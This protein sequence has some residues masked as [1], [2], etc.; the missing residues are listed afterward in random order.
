MRQLPELSGQV[1]VQ[2][3][4]LL[5]QA[6]RGVPF[7]MCRKSYSRRLREAVQASQ[8][9]PWICN[10]PHPA[11]QHASKHDPARC[12]GLSMHTSTPHVI[13]S[14]DLSPRLWCR[15]VAAAVS[16]RAHVRA[17]KDAAGDEAV[18][19]LALKTLGEVSLGPLDKL[20]A[21]VNEHVA[22]LMA[23]GDTIGLRRAAALAAARVL[24][25][26]AAAQMPKSP[27][28][29]LLADTATPAHLAVSG[30]LL[31][32]NLPPPPPPP[33]PAS[34]VSACC[35]CPSSA[36]GCVTLLHALLYYG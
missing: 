29:S 25:R 17:D 33:A 9:P 18:V 14:P 19:R 20:L 4:N 12:N 21:F 35:P 22:P 16:C 1:Q 34:P 27:Q 24:R 26:H 8:P 30:P 3:L 23:T 2:L 31:T 15:P 7:H 6:I 11:R 5:S 36:P 32:P 13:A 10:S 28:L